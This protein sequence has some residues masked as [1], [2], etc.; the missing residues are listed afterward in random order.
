MLPRIIVQ[1]RSIPAGF[2]VENSSVAD[3]FTILDIA[4]RRDFEYNM[5]AP[6]PVILLLQLIIENMLITVNTPGQI[7]QK[8]PDQL[9]LTRSQ[10]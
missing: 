6:I 8:F 1:V 5:A 4:I 10:F 9:Y 7:Y 2:K 3:L